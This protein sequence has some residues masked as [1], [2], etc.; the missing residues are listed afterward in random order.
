MR[1]H[2]LTEAQPVARS[3]LRCGGYQANSNSVANKADN[4]VHVQTLHYFAAMTFHR[5]DAQLQ[6]IGY[7]PRAVSRRNHPQYLDLT[8]SEL[9]QRPADGNSGRDRAREAT[10]IAFED[11]VLTAVAKACHRFLAVER[12]AHD[13]QRRGRPHLAEQIERGASIELRN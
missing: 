13:D 4:I 8:W 10:E 11:Y 1:A 6:S 12:A 9:V 3:P 7:L 2:V 5:L